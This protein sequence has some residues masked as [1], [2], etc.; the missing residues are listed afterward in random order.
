MF[1]KVSMKN[2]R[3]FRENKVFGHGHACKS[4]TAWYN[5]KGRPF[6]PFK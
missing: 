6:K 4:I 1:K 5:S 3:I 2:N